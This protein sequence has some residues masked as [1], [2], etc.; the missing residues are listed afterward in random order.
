MRVSESVVVEMCVCK[1]MSAELCMFETWAVGE[2]DM[3]A[4]R[5]KFSKVSIG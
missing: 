2:F 1:G 4:F 3:R 5:E